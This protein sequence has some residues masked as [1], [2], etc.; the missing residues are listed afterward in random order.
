MTWI[1]LV[2]LLALSSSAFAA[3]GQAGG[4]GSALPKMLSMIRENPIRRPILP[5]IPQAYGQQ[6]SLEQPSY[7]QVQQ[8][9]IPVA[10][11]SQIFTAPKVLPTQGYGAAPRMFAF[12]ETQAPQ[13]PQVPQIPIV[14]EADNL[15]RGQAPETVIPL[16]DGRR[17]V[18]C[19]DDGKGAEQ[20][21]PKGLVYRAST[22]RCE[23]KYGPQDYCL[24]QPCLNG[25][26]CLATDSSYQC[27]CAPGF[28]GQNC[29]LDARIC[30]TQS[31]CGQSPDA[32]CQSFR[33]GAAL[34]YICIF[35]DGLAYGL[36][37]TQVVPS[38]CQGVDGPQALSITNAGFI[39]C[40]GER[41]FVESCPGGTIWEDASKA[42]VW[43]DMQ[44]TVPQ[45]D[46]QLSYGSQIKPKL[47]QGYGSQILEQPKLIQGYGS[48]I[49]E[50]PKLIQGY[51]SQ[52]PEQPKLIQGYGSQIPEQPKLIQ[53]YGSQIPEQP[54]L[55]QGYGSQIPQ[56]PRLIQ[57]FDLP[58]PIQGYGSR[59]PEQPK[60]I[61]GYGSQIPEQP[62]L[63][64]GYGSQIPE[65][66]K[67]IQGYGSQIPEQPK[68]IQGY[69][70]QIPEQP[71]LLPTF[72][73]PIPAQA[74]GSEI[75]IQPVS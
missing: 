35:Q 53:G 20:S 39:M 49:P 8:P 38:P 52:I 41:M 47:I 56:Q 42:C 16:D 6:K 30:Q 75:T 72:E 9:Q 73:Q 12:D 29:E 1:S 63:I 15:C 67:L 28:D 18:V 32:R 57:R 25:G 61:Q 13:V 24:S 10:Y 64:Q 74:Y 62:K 36:S 17:F 7:G 60:L 55:I 22:R 5:V 71:K 58:K 43:P 40:D 46:E 37:N 3:Y 66:P 26:Q 54:K 21:C 27:Q 69:G 65:Q 33:L 48:Q 4:Y 34:Q 23:R 19:L 45:L 59:I 68:L 11:G 2:C 14:T 50:Q 51:G 70:S 31:P 44:T